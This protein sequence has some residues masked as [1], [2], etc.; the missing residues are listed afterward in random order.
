M[1]GKILRNLCWQKLK[2]NCIGFLIKSFYLLTQ[3]KEITGIRIFR[4]Y[5]IHDGKS[6]KLISHCRRKNT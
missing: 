4:K 2:A 3:G 6:K 5:N 1:Q